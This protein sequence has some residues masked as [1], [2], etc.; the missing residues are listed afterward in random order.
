MKTNDPIDALP[1]SD[2]VNGVRNSDQIKILICY[3]LC[4]AGVP[5]PR[6][7]ILNGLYEGGVANYFE[8]SSA[9]D[10]LAEAGA[11]ERIAG[12]DEIR[13]AAS[14]GADNIAAGLTGDLSDYL[15]E[16]TLSVLNTAIETDRRLRENSVC[17]KTDGSGKAVLEITMYTDASKTSELLSLRLGAANERQAKDLE[18][19]F[20]HDPTRLY[21]SIINALTK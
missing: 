2:S 16:K 19:V 20:L 3:A 12:G 6:R 13:F 15:K 4:G 10:E 7:V 1:V 8:I 14:E 18:K 17:V 11:L 9:L 21:E 5:I